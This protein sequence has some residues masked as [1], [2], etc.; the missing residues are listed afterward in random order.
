MK[1]AILGTGMVGRTLAAKLTSLEHDVM[2]GTRDPKQTLARKEKD[3]MGNPGYADWAQAHPAV[4]LATFAEAA[5]HGEIVFNALSGHATL[6]ALRLAGESHLAEKILV[7]ISNPLDFSKGMPPS[8]FACNTDS[9]G[10]QIQKAFPRT[11]V[12]KTLNIVNAYLMVDPSLVKSGDLSMLVSGNDA[13]AKA[14]VTGILRDWF[15]WKDVIDL[16]DI[17][18]A[19]GSEMLLPAWIRLWGTLQTPMFGFQ[20]LR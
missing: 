16:G 7:D 1:I 8:L 19:R 3:P 10:E 4:K 12:V 2:I 20:V 14:A 5:A 18:T 15:G 11:K 6:E 13:A 17:T 9:L